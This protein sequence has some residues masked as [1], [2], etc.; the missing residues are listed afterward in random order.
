M[1]FLVI[2]TDISE[3]LCAK[4][5]V[6]LSDIHS[7]ERFFLWRRLYSSGAD[8]NKMNERAL[9][10]PA[11]TARAMGRGAILVLCQ[12]RPLQRKNSLSRHPKS[13]EELSSS[14]T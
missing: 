2:Q 13:S 4:R 8:S 10:H 7:G 1:T 11:A 14:G 3:S 12:R 5:C 6:R 9:K